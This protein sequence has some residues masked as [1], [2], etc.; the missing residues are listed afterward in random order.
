MKPFGL[1]SVSL[2]IIAATYLAKKGQ[3]RKSLSTSGAIAAWMVGFLSIACGNRGFVLF[4][5]YQV[6]IEVM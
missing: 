6:C 2:G 3:K 1:S 4:M 5:F